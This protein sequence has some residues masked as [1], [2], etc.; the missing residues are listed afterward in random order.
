MLWSTCRYASLLTRDKAKEL[1]GISGSK[2]IARGKKTITELVEY[3]RRAGF[4]EIMII[5]E[6]EKKPLIVAGIKVLP[7][8]GFSWSEKCT[9]VEYESKNKH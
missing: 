6:S 1:A 7:A 9:L 4:Q 2:Y 8:G 5:E 3:A